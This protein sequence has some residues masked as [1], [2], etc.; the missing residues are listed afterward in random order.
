ML[1][2]NLQ[3]KQ[4][5]SDMIVSLHSDM[6]HITHRKVRDECVTLEIKAEK[7]NIIFTDSHHI[8]TAFCFPFFLFIFIVS[9]FYDDS[10][11]PVVFQ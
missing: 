2:N 1:Y 5:G 11:A 3:Y 6:N 4:Y 7:I 8:K 10:S 9:V